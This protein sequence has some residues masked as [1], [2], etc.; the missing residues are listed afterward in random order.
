M[1]PNA[2]G[3]Q[4]A[5][6]DSTAQGRAHLSNQPCLVANNTIA[7]I[8][9]AKIVVL[10]VRNI[11][12]SFLVAQVAGTRTFS[13]GLDQKACAAIAYSLFFSLYV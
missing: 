8:S 11:L 1:L 13:D 7:V 2:C 6:S 3:L 9:F 10:C 4:A 12:S 5:H